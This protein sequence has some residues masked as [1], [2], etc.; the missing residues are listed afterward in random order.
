M[1][2]SKDILWNKLHS[3]V[4]CL[5]LKGRDG[6]SAPLP[7]AKP[8]RHAALPPSSLMREVSHGACSEGVTILGLEVQAPPPAKLSSWSQ[9]F[10][11]SPAYKGVR[12]RHWTHYQ[13]PGT[14]AA[15]FPM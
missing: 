8:A 14:K 11:Q 1:G 10:P 5:D 4:A 9:L 13:L 15:L 6:G 7:P 12:D 2:Q 3:W